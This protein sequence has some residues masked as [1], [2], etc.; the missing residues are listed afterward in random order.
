MTGG[1]GAGVPARQ[2]PA[3]TQGEDCWAGVQQAAAVDVRLRV[4]P[5]PQ[6]EPRPVRGGGADTGRNGATLVP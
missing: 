2:R 5:D 6:E 3:P 4:R 1:M